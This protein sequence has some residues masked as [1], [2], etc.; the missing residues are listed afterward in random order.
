[1][2]SCW[3]L[4]TALWTSSPATMNVSPLP[5]TPSGPQCPYLQSR[6]RG[7]HQCSQV[8]F[9]S[10]RTGVWV[11]PH[12]G[13]GG[14]LSGCLLFKRPPCCSPGLAGHWPF[15]KEIRVDICGLWSTGPSV[16][17]LFCWK[18]KKKTTHKL[19]YCL[20]PFLPPASHSARNCLVPTAKEAATNCGGKFSLII[21]V[22]SPCNYKVF[23]SGSMLSASIAS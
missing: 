17:L 12:S 14:S 23:L 5:S 19:S 4:G 7:L 20:S 10:N 8:P 2:G 3:A 22:S 15:Q 11:C 16:P 13:P 9:C 18:K 1:M 6:R 21:Y